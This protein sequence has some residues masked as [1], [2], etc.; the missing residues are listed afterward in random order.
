MATWPAL[1]PALGGGS[2]D[3]LAGQLR[4]LV[5]GVLAIG[6]HAALLMTSW[7]T[8]V[9]SMLTEAAPVMAVRLLTRETAGL[10]ALAAPSETAAAVVPEAA[11]PP[12]PPPTTARTATKVAEPAQSPVV[13]TPTVAA[14]V[15]Q[16]VVAAPAPAPLADPGLP[17]APDYFAVGRLDPGPRPLEDIDPLYPEEAKQQEG[18]VVLRLLIN[19][20]GLVDNVAVVRAYPAGLF[21]ASA[22]EAFGKAKFSPGKMLGVAVKSQITIEVMFTPINRGKV[23]GRSY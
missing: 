1:R 13:A 14:K 4:V 9:G 16:D 11:V 15:T 6:L 21:E 23:S 22:L 20:S 8:L 7:P 17:P 3:R 10:G 2:A 18:S 12:S 5:A 19:E